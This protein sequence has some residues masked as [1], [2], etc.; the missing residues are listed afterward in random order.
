[1]HTPSVLA[2]LLVV[3]LGSCTTGEES[4]AS[5][6]PPTSD[7]SSGATSGSDEGHPAS[8]PFVGAWVDRTGAS[9]GRTAE[10]TNKVE[11]AD[12]D[13]DRDGDS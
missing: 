9:I 5:S 10:W 2:G 13:G 11:L 3:V 7:S 6:E 1:M 12:I 8:S 4:P